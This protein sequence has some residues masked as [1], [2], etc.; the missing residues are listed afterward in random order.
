MFKKRPF[1]VIANK[2]ARHADPLRPRQEKSPREEARLETDS[3]SQ[4]RA[5]L[6]MNPRFRLVTR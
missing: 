4:A 3:P 1:L 2:A 6:E 5:A